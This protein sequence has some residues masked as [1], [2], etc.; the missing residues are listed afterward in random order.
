MKKV[1][2]FCI[3]VCYA[4]ISF[5][6]S[7]GDYR[8]STPDSCDWS[9]STSWEVFNG[10]K[11][12][13]ANEPPCT[14]NSPEKIT[15][16][17]QC[18]M[19]VDVEV[20]DIPIK[21]L[22]IEPAATLVVQKQNFT[23]E[24]SV[25][26]QG[27][28]IYT[29]TVGGCVFKGRLVIDAGTM[30]SKYAT[31]C[32]IQSLE[33]IDS[34]RIDSE[35]R[36]ILD[37]QDSC[38]VRKH[39]VATIGKASL[40]VHNHTYIQGTIEFTSTAGEKEF[41]G[42]V[43]IHEGTWIST[44]GETFEFHNNLFIQDASMV[45]IG[46][47]KYHIH[48]NLV[49]ESAHFPRIDS[50]N[51][52]AQYIINDS[53]IC[54][55]NFSSTIEIGSFDCNTIDVFGSL[56]FT[57]K[58]GQKHIRDNFTIHTS[59]DFSNSGNESFSIGG[60]VNIHGTFSSGK[61][62][63]YYLEG[64]HKYIYGGFECYRLCVNGV[65]T[66]KC[67][68]EKPLFVKDEFAGTGTLIQDTNS[69]IKTKAPSIPN[70]VADVPNHI[71][72][73]GNKTSQAI[74]I[75]GGT[76]HTIILDNPKTTY[77]L[78]SSITIT[79]SLIFNKAQLLNVN[80]H[81]INFNSWNDSSFI[82][83]IENASRII[84][85]GGSITAQN[86]APLEKIFFPVALN[87][88]IEAF[89]GI[90]IQNID[91][92]SHDFTIDSLVHAV[93]EYPYITSD[94]PIQTQAVQCTY[95]I[96]SECKQAYITLFWH[97]AN[98]LMFFEKEMATIHHYNGTQWHKLI[99]E[100]SN[101]LDDNLHSITARTDSFS[102]FCIA[103]NTLLLPIILH[104]FT[105]EE[106]TEENILTWNTE[107]EKDILYFTVEKSYTGTDFFEL[108]HISSQGATNMQQTYTYSDVNSGVQ[109]YYRLSH[110]NIHGITTYHTTVSTNPP[111]H[112]YITHKNNFFQIRSTHQSTYSLKLYNIQGQ[113]QESAIFDNY[114]E[115]AQMAR[116]LYILTI[117]N[118]TT[119]QILN[120][121]MHL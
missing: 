113:L 55:E 74:R 108:A 52:Y 31:T 109:A 105:V 40:T 20:C 79:H 26:L 110:T 86:V 114:Y 67:V 7:F 9:S 100:N 111:T 63:V 91:S 90:E 94:N 45:N 8:T 38:I 58:V 117:T 4:S 47:A 101:Y 41:H 59:G 106:N 29:P 19:N 42:T 93:Y 69:Y 112:I 28:F 48:K 1:C 35:V 81:A 82:C 76:Y 61:N 56:D 92:V 116:G 17:T 84:L 66:N 95:F 85:D 2:F 98:E 43:H 120:Y 104:S 60:D 16:R 72:F 32:S 115:T 62:G 89:A 27:T 39:A 80:G 64:M 15:I 75:H 73:T 12:E 24:D 14:K 21:K 68:A 88:D 54:K 87:S 23:C 30:L 119:Q 18:Y 107:N 36:I 96:T 5:S 57:G 3:F 33:L 121:Y 118:R 83:S 70:I 13:S 65:Y 22:T 46:A 53:I 71:E 11:W 6:Q 51:I 77:T 99:T 44:V 78:D 25:L 102:P 50:T 103:S 10:E 34:L 37:I 49:L 97:E